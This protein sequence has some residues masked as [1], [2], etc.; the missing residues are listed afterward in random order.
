MRW[1]AATMAAGVVFASL[2]RLIAAATG[3]LSM[4]YAL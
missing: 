2:V 3:L 4:P 1:A